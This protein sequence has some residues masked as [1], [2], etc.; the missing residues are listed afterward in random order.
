MIGEIC[1]LKTND[2]NNFATPE[3]LYYKGWVF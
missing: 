3:K 2:Q 1:K